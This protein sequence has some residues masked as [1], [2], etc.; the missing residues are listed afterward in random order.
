VKATAGNQLEVVLGK[1]AQTNGGS[2][3]VRRFGEMMVRDHSEGEKELRGLAA[4]KQII[5][6]D[7][8]S[9]DQKKEVNDLQKKTGRSFDKAYVKMMVSDHKDDIGEFQK[10]S[11][12]AN[13]RDI[14]AIAAKM[15]PIL[16]MHLD[17]AQALEKGGE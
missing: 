3:G 6:P 13:D 9:N 5:L 1:M 4:S 7:T 12:K 11:Q 10:A 2:A 15:L 16:Q 14:K 8:I 17:S